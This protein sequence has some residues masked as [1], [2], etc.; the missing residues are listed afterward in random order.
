MRIEQTRRREQG[1]SLIEMLVVVGIIAIVSAIAL[2]NI[3]QY[4]RHYRLRGAADEFVGELQTARMT[5]VKKNVNYGVLFI[6]LTPTTYRYAIEDGQITPADVVAEAA[7]GHAVTANVGGPRVTMAAASAIDAIV[8]RPLQ[9][10]RAHE[11]PGGL[12]FRAEACALAGAGDAVRFSRLGMA[13]AA[14]AGGVNQLAFAGGKT[15][16]CIEDTVRQ[17]ARCVTM[18]DGGRARSQIYTVDTPCP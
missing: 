14:A 5:A 18:T 2:P 12:Q 3:M 8:R 1:F 7:R 9:A 6:I 10:G 13:A 4:L 16:L 11:L 17:L 15:Q